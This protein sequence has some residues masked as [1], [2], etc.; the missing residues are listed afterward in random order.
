LLE[1]VREFGEG[2]LVVLSGGDP[3]GSDPLCAYV[4][5]GYDS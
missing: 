5:D 1:D 3:L 4:P 2:Q